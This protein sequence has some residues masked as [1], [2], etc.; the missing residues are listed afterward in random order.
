MKQDLW[1]ILLKYVIFGAWNLERSDAWWEKGNKSENSH[2][3]LWGF[4]SDFFFVK[5][6]LVRFNSGIQSYF[7][8]NF[9]QYR[10]RNCYQCGE[11]LFDT[12]IP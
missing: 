7:F 11:W 10:E 9:A 2:I 3:F 6:D 1:D 4:R 12:F 5:E 8:F